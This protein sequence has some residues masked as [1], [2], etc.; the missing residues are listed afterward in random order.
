MEKQ[1]GHTFSEIAYL[2]LGYV[3]TLESK[4]PDDRPVDISFFANYRYDE[5]K[6]FSFHLPVLPVYTYFPADYRNREEVLATGRENRNRRSK[7]TT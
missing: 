2:P 1:Q 6:E 7:L 4:V 3:M 5:W